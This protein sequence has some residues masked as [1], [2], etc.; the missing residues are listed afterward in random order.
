MAGQG[1]V[2]GL[3][4]G[5]GRALGFWG[6]GVLVF[7]VCRVAVLWGC[8]EMEKWKLPLRV[9]GFHLGGAGLGRCRAYGLRV[10]R[11]LEKGLRV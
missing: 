1:Q 3:P 9:W 6:F 7:R 2:I 5:L 8:K 11:R 10:G 4:L